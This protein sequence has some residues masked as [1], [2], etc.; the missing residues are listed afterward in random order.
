MPGYLRVTPEELPAG[1]KA[2]LLF[3]HEGELCA[4]VLRRR[5]D[6]ALERIVPDDPVPS[7]LILGICRMMSSMPAEG[8]L[9]VVIEPL[10][11]WPEPFPLLRTL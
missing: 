3:V 6:G 5:H 11:Y 2:L 7:D 4:G 9:Y 1:H 8:D 10:A